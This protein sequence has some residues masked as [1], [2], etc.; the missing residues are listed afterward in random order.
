MLIDSSRSIVSNRELFEGA[1]IEILARDRLGSGVCR[2]PNLHVQSIVPVV[3]INGGGVAA[4]DRREIVVIVIVVVLDVIAQSHFMRA[5]QMIDEC[6]VVLFE[7]AIGI[8]NFLDP[9]DRVVLVLGF[10]L[11]QVLLSANLHKMQQRLFEKTVVFVKVELLQFLAGVDGGG[12]AHDPAI[13]VVGKGRQNAAAVNA[14]HLLPFV[15]SKDGISI[16]GRMASLRMTEKA[17]EARIGK[18]CGERAGFTR[19]GRAHEPIRAIKLEFVNDAVDI[20]LSD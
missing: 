8:G 10:E 9:E 18:C 15:I 6:R 12:L 19:Y 5:S 20:L 1:T 13:L 17:G 11:L 2:R 3:A 7:F 4:H 14:E 16:Q